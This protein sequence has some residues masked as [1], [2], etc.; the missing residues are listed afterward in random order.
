MCKRLLVT[1]TDL[2]MIQFLVPHIKYLSENGFD[3]EVA[4]SEVGG[5]LD[6][7]R[8]ALEGYAKA[9]HQVRLVRNPAAPVN[10]L[11]YGDM[12]RL[13]DDGH[14][15]VIWTNEPVMGVMTR[16]AARGARKRG[17][18]VLYMVHGF[19]FYK[20]APL[21][22]WLAFYP[23]ERTMASRADVIATVNREDYER[24][25]TMRVDRV[26]YIHG[27]GLNTARLH[28]SESRRDIRQEL[29]LA[30]NAFLVLSVGELN[31]NKNHR[32]IIKAIA[33][34]RDPTVHYIVCGKGALL[35]TLQKQ[36]AELGIA[37][38]VHF[39]GYRT[40]VV[41]IC[42]Q[43][44]VF[45]MP[46][47]REGMPVASLEAMYCG[48]PLVTSGVRGLADVMEDGVSGYV[49]PADDADA[50]AHRIQMLRADPESRKRMAE[51]N[52]EAVKEYCIENTRDEM[53]SLIRSL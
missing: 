5:R 53:L 4:C 19:H 43:A 11:G 15:D 32:T 6:E 9:V 16:L 45:A 7:V 48:L 25:K 17:T 51:R 2:M 44:D 22:N 31:E 34:L 3:V 12:K 52:R 46:S 29:G 20:G 10:L 41:D 33:L 23:I 42:A 36:A 30:E 24:A 1:S 50:F 37:D 39:L 21:A 18:K 35:E 14:F 38:Y 47:H 28:G 13:I 8:Q 27:I 26:E 49:C 40:D